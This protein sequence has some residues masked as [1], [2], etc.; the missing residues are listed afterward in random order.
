[1]IFP[2]GDRL[3]HF[4][5]EIVPLVDADDAAKTP[6]HMIE[7]PLDLLLD[8]CIKQGALQP[9]FRILRLELIL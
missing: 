5:H 8:M 3:V 1:M 4:W 7:L 9:Y 6:R 2:S